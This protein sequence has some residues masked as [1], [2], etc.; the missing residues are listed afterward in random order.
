MQVLLGQRPFGLLNAAPTKPA[1]ASSDLPDA[2][3]APR[4]RFTSHGLPELNY[5]VD[6]PSDAEPVLLLH[7]INAAP[8]AFEMKPLFDHYRANRRV[9]ALELPGFGMSDRS[10]RIYSPELYA[11]VISTFLTE[12]VRAPADVIAYSLSCEFAA[13][14][15]LQ[16]SAAFRCLVLLSPTG[17]SPRRLPSAKT[18]KLLHRL[19]SLPGLGS[20]VYALVTTRPSVRYFMKLSFVTTPPKELIDYAYATAHQPGARH[21]PFYFLS[22]QLFTHNPVEQLYGKLKQPVLVIHDR[23][24]NVSF[25]LLPALLERQSNWQLTRV[26]PTLGMPQWEQPQKTIAAIDAF[27]QHQA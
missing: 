13:R 15:A 9:Y 22:G 14:A 16:A 4:A 24:A 11:D 19:F 20:A 10:D 27:W 25:D 18:G 2:L 12:V 26:E 23:D 3:D 8:S 5:Y 7:S 17:F 1:R 6:G 21:A